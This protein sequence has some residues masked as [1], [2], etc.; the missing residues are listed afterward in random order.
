LALLAATAV[1]YPTVRGNKVYAAQERDT[2][3]SNAGDQSTNLNDQTD[4]NVTVY[5]SNIALIRDVR[6]LHLQ[7]RGGP[8]EIH[9]HRRHASIPRPSTFVRLND[10][11][12]LGV[13]EQNYESRFSSSHAKLLHNTSAR[14]S[15]W[16][17]P[18]RK[19]AP[20]S[21]KKSMATLLSDNNGPV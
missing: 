14:K 4:L 10:P 12:K 16:C 7:R 9:G 15:R 3:R 8:P 5:N 1:L 21:T 17:A 6:N 19:T 18:I 11:E 2:A 20:P 13:I